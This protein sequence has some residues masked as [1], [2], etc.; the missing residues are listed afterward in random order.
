MQSKYVK[1][2]VQ[3]IKIMSPNEKDKTKNKISAYMQQQQHPSNMPTKQNQITHKNEQKT[4][5]NL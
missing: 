5:K 4:K 3:Q 1:K 2:R